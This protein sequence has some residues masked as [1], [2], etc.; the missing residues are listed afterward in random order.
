MCCRLFGGVWCSAN[1]THA[2]RRRLELEPADGVDPVI[3]DTILNSFYADDCL[4][5]TANESEVVILKI[6]EVPHKCGFNL[7]NFVVNYSRLLT[8]VSKDKRTEEAKDL[9]ELC[10]VNVR[11]IRLHVESDEFYFVTNSS[12]NSGS[13]R[14][15]ILRTLPSVRD[16]LGLLGPVVLLGKIIFQATRRQLKWYEPMPSDLIEL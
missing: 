6:P 8:D 14:R 12:K 13:T 4:K 3:S 1:S 16:P 5:S 9:S 10:D 7:T 11:G 15:K 2:L